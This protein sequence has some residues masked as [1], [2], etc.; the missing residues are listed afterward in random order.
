MLLTS[1]L[2][3]LSETSKLNERI[4]DHKAKCVIGSRKEFS[5]VI[6]YSIKKTV[7]S[8]CRKNRSKRQ[9]NMLK[10]MAC[11]NKVSNK[12]SVCYN[13]FIDK[14][15]GIPKATNKKQIPHACW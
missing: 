5:S 1:L 13:S 8:M 11:A 6:I 15:Q 10:S 14:L 2:H 4:D 12:T 9:E 3:I 7:K